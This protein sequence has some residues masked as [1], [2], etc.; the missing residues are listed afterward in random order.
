MIFVKQLHLHIMV[1]VRDQFLSNLVVINNISNIGSTILSLDLPLVQ[2]L[3]L[4]SA[5]VQ[6]FRINLRN[7][8]FV[9]Q[10]PVSVFTLENLKILIEKELISLEVLVSSYLSLGVV[11]CVDQMVQNELLTTGA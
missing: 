2:L 4:M 5:L 3:Q 8:R 11:G 7:V 9:E 10:K 6:S 1:G